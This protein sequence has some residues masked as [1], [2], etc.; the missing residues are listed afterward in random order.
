MSEFAEYDDYDALGLADLIREGHISADEIVETAIARVEQLNPSLNAVVTPMFEQARS[1]LHAPRE[2]PLGGVPFLLKDLGGDY[3]GV[4][5]RRGSKLYQEDVA[6]R[7]A[8]IVT[9]YHRAGLVVIGKTN[10]PELGL[11]VSTEPVVDGPA[12]NPWNTDHSTGGSSGGSAAAVAAGIV[13]AAHATDGGGS[14]RIP[15]SCCGVFGLKPTRGRVSLG[16]AVGEGWAGMS[17]GHAVT[18]SVRDSAALLDAVAGPAPG[19]P[20]SAAPPESSFL[21]SLQHPCAKLRIG[22][23]LTPP[24]HAT[25]HPTCVAAVRDAAAL[26]EQLGHTITEVQLPVDGG[27][28]K[29][30]TGVVIQTKIAELL[31]ARAEQLS[32]PLNPEDVERATW[33]VYQRGKTVTGVQYASAVE[34]IHRI[35]RRVAVLMQSYDMILSP[36][37]A[38]P[39]AL[40]GRLDMTSDDPA[41]FFDDLG[42]YSPFTNLANVTGQPAMS[43]PLYWSD[44][45]LPIGVQFSGRYG[46]EVSLFQLAQQ[47]EQTRP[48]GRKHRRP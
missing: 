25:V 17:T 31:D 11:N 26:C 39:P 28:L 37:L 47:L 1:R 5:T 22:L 42:R 43:V 40:L 36:V 8:E 46:A 21:A 23:C 29:Y 48:W 16:P 27:E 6:E 44:E 38:E 7:D 14:I 33:A 34:A 2:G 15:A 41:G 19:D 20:Y 12:R 35:G 3:R 24:N 9:R 45:G 13:P 18:R 4:A 10:T 30:N 32:R